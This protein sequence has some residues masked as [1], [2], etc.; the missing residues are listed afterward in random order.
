M[1]GGDESKC[2][3]DFATDEYSEAT[4]A[5]AAWHRRLEAP[6]EAEIERQQRRLERLFG[7]ADQ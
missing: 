1:C 3:F 4:R 5:I 7:F 2:D 6:T